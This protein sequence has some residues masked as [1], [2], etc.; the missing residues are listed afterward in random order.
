[1]KETNTKIYLLSLGCAKNLVNSELMLGRLRAA[2]ME[3]C[4]S[5]TGA[6]AAIVN[7]CGFI[8]S[9]KSEAIE[10]ILE[11]AELK[12]QGQIRALIVT[13]CLTQ[14]YQ[15]EFLTELPE[16]DAALG[17]GSYDSIVEAVRGA[18]A[19]KEHSAYFDPRENSLLTGE[20]ILLTPGYSAYLRIA[21]GCDNGCSFCVIP[22]IRGRFR[23]VPM[24]E[25]EAEARRLAAAGTR[26]LLIVAQ[27]ITRYGLDLYGKCSLAALLRRLERVE[28]LRW[29]RLHY[30]YPDE[31]DDELLEVIAASRKIL[32]YFDIPIQHVNDRI[33]KAMNRRG[34]GALIR[35]RIARLRT[36]VPDAIIRTSLI[37]GFPGETEAEY[38]ELYEFLEEYR[39][40]RVGVFC[41]SQEEGTA[42]AALPGQIPETVKERRRAEIY[43]LQE[44][45]MDA[46]SQKQIGRTLEI[47][48][49]GR[50]E[51]GCFGRSYMDSVDIDGTVYFTS[52]TAQEGDFVSVCVDYA[53]G[54]D[55]YG[56]ALS[57][58]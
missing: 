23:S 12:K 55:L 8:D 19:G 29:I 17:T 14:R 25:L 15:G 5:P 37:V 45:I 13:G 57:E 33:L 51:E 44:R 43:A 36:L 18:L 41:Y 48:C 30:L 7:T 52:E 6:D 54:C 21:E 1:M 24:E 22:K 49:C 20:R 56:R 39:L 53:E 38:R 42:A 2:G 9:A 46:F 28:G 11:L 31:M 27:D 40:E 35:E 3:I 16:V 4:D 26:E 50:D 10:A 47:L 32:H 58:V 34:S